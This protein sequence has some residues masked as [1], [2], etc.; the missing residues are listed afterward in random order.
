M[1]TISEA[2]TQEVEQI[3]AL[4]QGTG[5]SI[6]GNV[7]GAY[8]V[9]VCKD[10]GG[11]VGCCSLQKKKTT[12]LRMKGLWV[13]P[14]HRRKGIGTMLIKHRIAEAQKAGAR[15]VYANCS[16]RSVSIW[17]SLGARAVTTYANGYTKVMMMVGCVSH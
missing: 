17:Q 5:V 12:Q 3:K 2:T 6:E 15:W 10:N 8:R 11:I 9:F 13:K 4:L 14:T 16:K 7:T 1:L